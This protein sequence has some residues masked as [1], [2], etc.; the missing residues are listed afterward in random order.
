MEIKKIENAYGAALQ[1]KL[2]QGEHVVLEPGAIATIKGNYDFKTE[3]IGGLGKALMR[4]FGAGE[5][6]FLNKVTA[7]D[8]TEVIVAPPIPGDIV[9]IDVDG[10]LIVGDGAF[11]GYVGDLEMETLMLKPAMLVSGQGLMVLKVKGKGKVF[12]SA[13]SGIEHS[14]VEEGMMLDNDVFIAADE[15]VDFDIEIMK[16][17][18]GDLLGMVKNV[19][20]SGEGIML[21]PKGNGRVFY[22]FTG[23]KSLVSYILKFI[24]V[25]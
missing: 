8:T 6:L 17:K 11:V 18:G 2:N 7:H 9:S 1:V 21:K 25:R 3:M 5:S 13:P 19:L 22:T 20:F 10:G 4:A 14:E 23:N 12:V 24:K 16:N 15:S